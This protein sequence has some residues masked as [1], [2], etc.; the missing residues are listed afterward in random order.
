MIPQYFTSVGWSPSILTL[1]GSVAVSFLMETQLD[2]VFLMFSGKREASSQ[3]DTRNSITG[4]TRHM[5]DCQH[6]C[7]GLYR[8]II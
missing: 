1:K 7:E 3:A 4:F 8:G 2:L 6:I 5:D